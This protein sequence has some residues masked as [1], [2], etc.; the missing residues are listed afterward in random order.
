MRARQ[1]GDHGW[2]EWLTYVR[3]A[4]VLPTSYTE[5]YVGLLMQLGGVGPE[6][7]NLALPLE[8]SKGLWFNAGD[9]LNDF[10]DARCFWG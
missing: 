4:F 2:G 3:C 10:L 1:G 9:D 7:H 5:V 8:L 6:F